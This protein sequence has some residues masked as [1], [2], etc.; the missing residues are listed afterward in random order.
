MRDARSAPAMTASSDFIPWWRPQ[1]AEHDFMGHE[2]H[3]R[4]KQVI[5]YDETSPLLYKQ[6]WSTKTV[7][8]GPR[9]LVTRKE[10]IWD[11]LDWLWMRRRNC[12][13]CVGII[14]DLRTTYSSDWSSGKEIC[15]VSL[16]LQNAKSCGLCAVFFGC[17]NSV[18]QKMVESHRKTCNTTCLTT[19]V[20]SIS[21]RDGADEILLRLKHNLGDY[22]LAVEVNLFSRSGLSHFPAR[23]FCHTLMQIQTSSHSNALKPLSF[24]IWDT[25]QARR[26]RGRLLSSGTENVQDVTRTADFL[27]LYT[28]QHVSSMSE[29]AFYA[30]LVLSCPRNL[31]LAPDTLH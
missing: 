18:E 14:R 12:R 20:C 22:P 15:Q 17:L 28:F 3:V 21:Q 2:M 24:G 13:M 30:L 25:R 9:E 8:V 5:Y 26:K 31:L 27:I 1:A 11:R 23:S 7:P 29:L 16:L 6:R 10:K 4:T 19:F